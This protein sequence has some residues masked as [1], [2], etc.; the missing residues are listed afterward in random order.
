MAYG[1]SIFFNIKFQIFKLK[2]D[3]LGWWRPKLDP[4]WEY[5][6]GVTLPIVHTYTY[7]AS[8][9][10]NLRGWHIKGQV[11]TKQNVTICLIDLTH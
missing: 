10:P 4:H 5:T 9:C 2:G 11:R 6:L 8:S 1:K 3:G 7:R